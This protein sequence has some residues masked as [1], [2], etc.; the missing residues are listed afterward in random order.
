MSI[1]ISTEIDVIESLDMN[2]FQELEKIMLFVYKDMDDVEC[3]SII[4]DDIEYFLYNDFSSFNVG[5]QKSIMHLTSEAKGVIT[6][7]YPELLCL[8][9]RTKTNG[10]FD[11]FKS[12]HM[13]RKDIFKKIPI[14]KI[15]KLLTNFTVGGTI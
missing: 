12:E 11:K 6:N 9:L 8:F 14:N 5:E 15:N 10:K 3:E 13:N 2:S 7:K 1:L 4:I